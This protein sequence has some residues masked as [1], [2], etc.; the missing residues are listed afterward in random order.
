MTRVLY[1]CERNHVIEG[2]SSNLCINGR[3]T[4]DVPVCALRCN[5]NF[6]TGASIVP[7]NCSLNGVE[8]DCSG[9]ARPGTKAQIICRDR[10][11]RTTVAR[12]QI[13]I[14]D[15]KGTWAPKLQICTP[16]CGELPK[17]SDN[18]TN[19][20][21][22]PWHAS[23][24]KYNGTAFT[25][26]CAGTIITTKFILSAFDCFWD[27]NTKEPFSKSLFRVAVGKTSTDYNIVGNLGEQILEIERFAF[28]QLY[29]GVV[30][31]ATPFVM[32]VILK[33]EIVFTS[34]IGPIC[35]P[36]GVDL[37]HYEMYVGEGNKGNIAKWVKTKSDEPTGILK[38]VVIN[39][40]VNVCNDELH[41]SASTEKCAHLE[42]RENGVCI[43]DLGSGVVY[44]LQELGRTIY[45]LFFVL[46]IGAKTE[47]GC[48]VNN[49]MFKTADEITSPLDGVLSDSRNVDRKS[50]SLF[51]TLFLFYN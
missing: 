49:A 10:Y 25:Y 20:V 5:P 18:G 48:K 15:E 45:Y 28:D 19:N 21:G 22:I 32:N 37:D 11:K 30:N 50:L 42:A 16:I 12:K 33:T 41:L 40:G 35:V 13:V 43:H 3:W 39:Y 47:N 44:P 1:K 46:T 36:Y 27:I 23:I 2:P 14:C 24:Y 4:N 17:V 38:L 29:I 51:L 7:T 6:I 34:Y 8:M 26:R 31:F 9:P